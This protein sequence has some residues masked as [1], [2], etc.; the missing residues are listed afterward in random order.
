MILMY[1]IISIS[2]LNLRYGINGKKLDE[3][4]PFKC[5]CGCSSKLGKDTFVMMRMQ[6]KLDNERMDVVLCGK[7]VDLLADIIRNGPN[8]LSGVSK[9]KLQS[10]VA[11]VSLVNNNLF[12]FKC[13]GKQKTHL[14]MKFNDMYDPGIMNKGI[15]ARAKSYGTIRVCAQC[16]ISYL[17]M[18]LSQRRRLCTRKFEYKYVESVVMPAW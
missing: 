12:C 17:Q 1:E 9:W 2:S 11:R 18:M 5:S 10:R 4:I 16:A 7:C 8:V 3:P 6:Y 15:Q 14:F 13:L